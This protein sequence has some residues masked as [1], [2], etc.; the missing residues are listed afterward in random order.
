MTDADNFEEPDSVVPVMVDAVTE[1]IMLSIVHD[2]ARC[3][4]VRG[5]KAARGMM[6]RIV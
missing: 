6:G 4:R 1:P 2:N 3:R 5:A